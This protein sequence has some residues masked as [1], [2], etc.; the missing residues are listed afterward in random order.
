[1]LIALRAFLLLA[2]LILPFH[3]VHAEETITV[4]KSA[5]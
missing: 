2:S 4:Y 1:V 5:T 3:A